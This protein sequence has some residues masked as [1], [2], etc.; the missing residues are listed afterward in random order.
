MF[1]IENSAFAWL[2]LNLCIF[3]LLFTPICWPKIVWH[4]PFCQSNVCAPRSHWTLHFRFRLGIWLMSYRSY[5]WASATEK[6][7]S[8]AYAKSSLFPHHSLFNHLEVISWFKLK[9]WKK[10]VFNRILSCDSRRTQHTSIVGYCCCRW[11]NQKLCHSRTHDAHYAGGQLHADHSKSHFHSLQHTSNSILYILFLISSNVMHVFC[12]CCCF[13]FAF[14]AHTDST[15]LYMK[16]RHS[17]YIL[18]RNLYFHN[19]MAASVRVR[20][21]T[22]EFGP[23][24][25][26]LSSSVDF[27]IGTPPVILLK[28]TFQYNCNAYTICIPHGT[29][30]YVSI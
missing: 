4:L 18:Y 30:R 8:S 6:I 23:L 14:C 17:E 24:F 3:F 13:F 20:S 19:A 29:L 9:K 1:S 25:T 21:H 16:I 26:S 5:M 7:P 22:I 15:T 28:C 11:M 27:V 2:A 10:I 12:C